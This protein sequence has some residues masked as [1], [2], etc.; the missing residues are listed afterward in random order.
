[1]FSLIST[2]D[3]TNMYVT[4]FNLFFF[5]C[6]ANQRF[7]FFFVLLLFVCFLLNR[8]LPRH[9]V[10]SLSSIAP[11]TTNKQTPHSTGSPSQRKGS[12]MSMITS[13]EAKKQSQ[14]SSS[15]ASSYKRITSGNG[16]TK[17]K[18]VIKSPSSHKSG[19][20]MDEHEDEPLHEKSVG[21]HATL[22]S[23]VLPVTCIRFGSLFYSFCVSS[24]I[25][26]IS[27]FV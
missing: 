4:V 27:C 7:F 10:L 8:T 15:S 21:D 6:H 13:T 9:H 14:L 24:D 11:S 3:V 23:I 26:I 2:I 17:Q 19:R 18:L 20:F 5:G 12:N 1:M 22:W 25:N 16:E